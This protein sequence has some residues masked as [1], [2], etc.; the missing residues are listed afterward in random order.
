MITLHDRRFH[1]RTP[2][3]AP[4]TGGWKFDG[5]IL[6]SYLCDKK[7]YGMDIGSHSDRLGRRENVRDALVAE[8]VSNFARGAAA[9]P[10]RWRRRGNAVVGL[11]LP[12][13][14][15]SHLEMRLSEST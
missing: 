14:R 5:L 1:F 6:L 9:D 4:A 2:I 8:S 15:N 10:Q 3:E 7:G 12:T 13:T 11:G